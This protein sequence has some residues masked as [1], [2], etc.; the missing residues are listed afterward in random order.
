[1]GSKHIIGSAL[2]ACAIG[3]API[4]RC[5]ELASVWQYELTLGGKRPVSTFYFSY[6]SRD[7]GHV[8]FSEPG[9]RTEPRTALFSTDPR[10]T[11]SFSMVATALSA[12]QSEDLSVG[13]VLVGIAGVVMY[14]GAPI[15]AVVKLVKEPGY[16]IEPGS[17]CYVDC[18][19]TGK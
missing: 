11:T 9:A 15:A 16:F 13:K 6:Q 18:T 5:D 14:L 1:M 4:A 7:R 12:D 2:L 10:M 17:I 19:S 8:S 3:T